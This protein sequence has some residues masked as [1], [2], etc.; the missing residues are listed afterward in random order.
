MKNK[1]V[2][3]GLGLGLALAAS[4]FTSGTAKAQI[5][6]CNT[7]NYPGWE[8]GDCSTQSN[9][10]EDE[11]CWQCGNDAS[12]QEENYDYISESCWADTCS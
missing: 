7:W 3:A 10:T 4:L 6:D 5:Y 8:S 2:R 12:C 9:C 1:L 11:V